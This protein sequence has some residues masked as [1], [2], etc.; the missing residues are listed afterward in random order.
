MVRSFLLSLLVYLSLSLSAQSFVDNGGYEMWHG[1]VFAPVHGE[2][3]CG[4]AL[5]TAIDWTIPEQLMGMATNHFSY[6]EEDTTR[7]HSGNF[8]VKMYTA[9]TYIDSAG[10]T[11]GTGRSLVLVPGPVTCAG[12]I[13][14]GSMSLTGDLSKTIAV[15]GGQPFTETP[16]ALYFYMMFNHTALDTARYAYAFTR[17]D[18]I[19]MRRDTL[20]SADVDIPDDD[21][22]MNQWILFSDS[23]H[24]RMGGSPDTLRLIFWGGR[25][26]DSTK[27]GNVTWLDDVS[28]DQPIPGR[29]STTI[30]TGVADVSAA[31][32]AVY[33][34]PASAMLYVRTAKPTAGG[35]FELYDLLGQRAMSGSLTGGLSAYSIAALQDGCYLYRIVNAAGEQL[36]DGKLSVAKNQ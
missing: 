20:A 8:S 29:T 16:S 32:I 4:I 26:N 28:F 31:G 19:N 24:Y 7:I 3:C 6:R 33:P 18:S 34:N 2:G 27:A 36:Q 11:T 21:A 25:N 5:A 14:Y 30:N 13:A 15:S 10:D 12:I 22:V 17:W 23:I 35:S 1:G 9:V